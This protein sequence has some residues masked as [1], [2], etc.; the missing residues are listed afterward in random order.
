MTDTTAARATPAEVYAQRLQPVSVG[1]WDVHTTLCHFS[2]VNYAVAA[3]KLAKFIPAERFEISEFNI[4]GN[5]MA[6][7][8]AVSFVD[9]DF[10]FQRLLPFVRFR[11]AQTNH[12]A[13]VIDKRTGQYG[14][15]FF[16]TTLGSP[17]VELARSLWRIPWHQAHYRVE[18]SYNDAK[19]R[20]MAYHMLIESDWC[21]AQIN[22][23]DSGSGLALQEGFE[24]MDEMRLIL[25]HPVDGFYNRLDGVPGRYS[26]WH[27]RM[28]MTLGQASELYFSLYD[29]LGLLSKYDM[30]HPHSVFLCPQ[31]PFQIHLP[32]VVDL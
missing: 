21:S 4:D 16:G 1:L 32:P 2:Q 10:R 27:D 31:V 15:W 18:C 28:E 24:T 7:L 29:R 9:V 30:Q 22:I 23:W 14:V 11:F 12:R 5:R 6:M 20:Y 3:R 8:S 13:Y 25:T 26:I 17:V 19:R